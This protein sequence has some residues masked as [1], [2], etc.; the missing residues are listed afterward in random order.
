MGTSNAHKE[1]MKLWAQNQSIENQI[2]YNQS[3]K[4]CKNCQST[5]SYQKRHTNNFCNQ[6]CSASYN[7]I[8]KERKYKFECIYCGELNIGK[9]GGGKYCNS[10]CAN[11]H[12]KLKTKIEWFENGKVP[13]W[14]ALK[15]IIIEERGYKCEVCGISEWNNKNLVLE[16]DHING[17]HTNNELDNLRIIC[18]NC[19]SQTDTYKAKN[20][21][22]GRH[23][24]RERYATGQSY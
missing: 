20:I 2:K 10:Q 24:R 9:R 3:P 6:S 11:N 21:G 7:N 23:Y 14:K 15:N 8:R 16:L 19:H 22:N 5:I 4:L 18:P 1:A 12:K 17:L 13:S